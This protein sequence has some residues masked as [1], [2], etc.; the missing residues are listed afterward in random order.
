MAWHGEAFRVQ[1]LY[2]WKCFLAEV[3]LLSICVEAQHV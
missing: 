1:C 3:V 2:G